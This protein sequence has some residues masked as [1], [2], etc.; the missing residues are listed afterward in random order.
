MDTYASNRRTA[1][2]PV[3]KSII[4]YHFKRDLYRINQYRPRIN[5]NP[6]YGYIRF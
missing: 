3:A 2:P 4:I 5:A 1:Y 6:L